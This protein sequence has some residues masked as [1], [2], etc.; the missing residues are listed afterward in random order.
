MKTEKSKEKEKHC[1]WFEFLYFYFSLFIF[2]IM[3]KILFYKIDIRIIFIF[4]LLI[5]NIELVAGA[6]VENTDPNCFLGVTNGMCEGS[7]GF[8]C[9]DCI[10]VSTES[11]ITIPTTTLDRAEYLYCI[12]DGNDKEYCDKIFGIR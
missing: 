7:E 9:S 10:S 3:W 6:Y 12:K 8:S 1:F 5:L 2:Y 4:I 11:T